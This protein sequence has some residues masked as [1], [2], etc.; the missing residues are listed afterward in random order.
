MF[1]Y[2]QKVHRKNEKKDGFK[3]KKITIP[4][5][6]TVVAPK[7]SNRYNW[8]MGVV[9]R[10]DDDMGLEE[11]DRLYTAILF[12]CN[13]TAEN[14]AIRFWPDTTQLKHN[15]KKPMDGLEGR[16]SLDLVGEKGTLVF[17]DSN[18]LHQSLPNVTESER[19]MIA[20]NIVVKK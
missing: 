20:W 14:G 4:A 3:G 9:H 7:S 1:G 12:L 11:G 13:V 8:R 18:I 17:F 10:D 19:R 2:N 16:E 6:G 5:K 15:P